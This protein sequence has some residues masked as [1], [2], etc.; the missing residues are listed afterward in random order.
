MEGEFDGRGSRHRR[1]TIAGAIK[2]MGRELFRV[3]HPTD[4]SHIVQNFYFFTLTVNVI[5]AFLAS[6]PTRV[7]LEPHL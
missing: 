7:M 2:K 3:P 4:L 1:Q 6:A 5:S